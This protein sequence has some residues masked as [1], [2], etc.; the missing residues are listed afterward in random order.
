MNSSHGVGSYSRV[1]RVVQLLVGIPAFDEEKTIAS[2][3]QRIP[4]RIDGVTKISVVVVDDGSTDDTARLA[5]E[6]GAHVL[7]HP[8]NSGV[9]VAFQTMVRHALAVKADL[10]VT[11]DADGQF[12]P[13]HIPSLIAPILEGKALAATATRFKD[14]KLIP[15]M[16]WIKK[17]GNARVVGLVNM[18]TGLKY[19]D[20]SCGFRAYTREALLRLTIYQSFTYTHETFLDLAAKN[21]PIAEVPLE[22]RGVREF[23]KSKVASNV[24]KYGIRT[25]KIMLYTYRDQRPLRLCGA[26]AVPFAVLGLAL[27]AWSYLTFHQS[28]NWLKW[29]A[30]VGAASLG[31]AVLTL[32]FGFMADMATRLRRNQEEMLYWLRQG[33]QPPA[34]QSLP[35]PSKRPLPEADQL[36]QLVKK[37]G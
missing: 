32:F 18:L 34:Q 37:S 30:F 23:G 9:G 5:R 25:S 19:T 10:L 14:P 21:V 20:V 24:L 15:Q 35:P 12:N 7:R 29:A 22:V 6:A 17:W 13:T 31:T 8:Q 26:L 16:P 36:P 4:A 11:L 3:I 27:V 28:G 2:V 1:P 33:A